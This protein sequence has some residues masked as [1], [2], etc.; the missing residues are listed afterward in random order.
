MDVK[1][2]DQITYKIT[3]QSRPV[4]CL[5]VTASYGYSTDLMYPR[6]GNYEQAKILLIS[7]SLKLQ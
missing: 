1:I 2:R 3:K 5:S 6:G 7:H 4:S